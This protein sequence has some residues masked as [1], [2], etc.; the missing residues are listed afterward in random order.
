M[1]DK[2]IISDLKSRW[3]KKIRLYFYNAWCSWTKAWIEEDNL[4]DNLVLIKTLEEIDIYSN[5]IDKQKFIDCKIT[6]TISKDHNWK[7]KVRY[8]YTS[9]KVKSRCWCGTSFS[10]WE[11]NIVFDINKI[12]NIKLDFKK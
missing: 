2:N 6:K 8:I 12:K 5:I 10:F 3:I 9:S 1:L 7:E 4:T 11:K